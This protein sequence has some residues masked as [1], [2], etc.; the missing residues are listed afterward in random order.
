MTSKLGHVKQ[1]PCIQLPTPCA[2][3]PA[4]AG[5][6]A[7]WGHQW[8]QAV[9]LGAE[10]WL[11]PRVTRLPVLLRGRNRALK[12]KRCERFPCSSFVKASRI[13]GKRARE[14]VFGHVPGVWVQGGECLQPSFQASHHA[15]CPSQ[16]GPPEHPVMAS[17]EDVYFSLFGAYSPGSRCIHGWFLVRA[18]SCFQTAPRPHVAFHVVSPPLLRRPWS[19]GVTALPL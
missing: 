15:L 2:G 11:G 18:S 14:V 12:K 3:D 19:Y 4:W 13:P 7:S 5:S 9:L 16:L 6:V 10:C 8:P 17:T 1:Q